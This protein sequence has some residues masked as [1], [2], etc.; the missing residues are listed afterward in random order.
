[1]KVKYVYLVFC[2]LG[3]VLPYIQMA[4][5]TEQYA[6]DYGPLFTDIFKQSS[7][8]FFAY[9]LLI[10]ALVGIFFMVVESRRIKMKYSW[11]PIVC[12]V[13]IGFAFG[14]PLFMYM[15]EGYSKKK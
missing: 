11:V 2:V 1:M 12:T 6:F 10:A 15:R 13:F 5:Y 3:L 14:L 9:D 4:D 8:A 7:T